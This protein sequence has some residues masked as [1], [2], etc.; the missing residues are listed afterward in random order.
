MKERAERRSNEIEETGKERSRRTYANRRERERERERIIF[1][2]YFTRLVK[3]HT[4]S[5]CKN[6]SL[7]NFAQR[8]HGGGGGEEVYH[9]ENDDINA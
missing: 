4:F 1:S 3:L 7:V 6:E 8:E 9:G 5:G 2:N